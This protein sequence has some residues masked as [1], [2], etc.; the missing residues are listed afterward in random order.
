MPNLFTGSI[1]FKG[2]QKLTHNILKSLKCEIGPSSP[3]NDY[4]DFHYGGYLEVLNNN[5][6]RFNFKFNSKKD[7]LKDLKKWIIDFD[8]DNI[9]SESSSDTQNYKITF[10]YVILMTQDY[11]YYKFQ[12][13]KYIHKKFH[14]TSKDHIY[15]KFLDNTI[16]DINYNNIIKINPI[17]IYQK[18]DTSDIDMWELVSVSGIHY[19]FVINDDS[20]MDIAIGNLFLFIKKYGINHLEQ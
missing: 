20:G 10:A 15:G 4:V 5:K 3:A 14:V 17:Y 16:I 11:G 6:F 1:T 2:N 7:V 13:N 8:I 9:I 18:F 12:Q 19:P